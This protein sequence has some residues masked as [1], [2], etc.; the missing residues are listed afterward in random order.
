MRVFRSVAGFLALFVCLGMA[1]QAQRISS[2]DELLEAGR[3]ALQQKQYAEA[4]RLLE[5]GQKQ[6]PGDQRLKLELGRAYLYDRQDARAIQ[7]FREILSADPSNRGAKLELAR[8]LGYQHDFTAS[9]R[10]YRELLA[11]DPDDE[12]AAAGL[13]RNLMHE[14]HY[15]EARA[16][17]D[18]ALARHPGSQR[19]Q[20][21][22]QRLDQEE[23]RGKKGPRRKRSRERAP[24]ATR[25]MGRAQGA[26]AYFSNSAG[27]RSWRLTQQF[28]YEVTRKLEGR[29]HAEER[30]L[31]TTGG[32]K[33]DVQWVAG[34]LRWRLAPFLLFSGSGG[35]ARFADAVSRSI[36]RGDL[37][38]HPAKR[39]WII[40]GFSRRPV[41]PTFL[42]TQFD[43]LAEGWHGSMDWNPGA[44]RTRTN[45]T[46]EHYSDGNLGKRFDT[47]LVDW[48]GVPQFS[49]AA[50]LRFRYL[51]FSQNPL[52]GYFSPSTYDSLEGVT[53]IKF[54][55]RKTFR[56]EYTGGV[57]A[58]TIAGGPYRTAWEIA[59]RNRAQFG[60]LELGLDYFYFHLA[61]TTG[62]FTSQA[63]RF[64]LAY[65]F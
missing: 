26:G 25:R 40:G 19:L 46:R 55:L 15:A 39:L 7:V 16:Q 52:H 43:V 64:S 33:A 45:F 51:A 12:A 11:S 53:G 34:E 1:A 54:K 23:A 17:L 32:P 3:A 8:A 4:I 47:E 18:Q 60:S 59:L 10:L 44:L 28:G 27:S 56:A 20:E 13:V 36:Y 30:S 31:W 48:I 35:S 22:K 2:A 29:L 5:D 57:G 62:A 14:K 38:L 21:Y 9:G 24:A 65:S 61:Q 58:E 42:S 41:S 6:F 37:E 49:V 63:T 50:G